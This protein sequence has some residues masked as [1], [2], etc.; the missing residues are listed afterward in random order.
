LR[1]RV[2]HFYLALLFSGAVCALTAHEND[3][4]GDQGNS[5]A[6]RVVGQ[7]NTPCPNAQ[8]TTI[9]AAVT[10]ANPGDVIAIC[11]ALYPEQLIIR[12]PLTLRGIPVNGINRIL[13][14]PALTDLR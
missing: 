2:T 11:P 5:G 12:K 6:V 9:G 3:D 13:V 14:Q 4:S 10:A 1:K 8:Y 7:P